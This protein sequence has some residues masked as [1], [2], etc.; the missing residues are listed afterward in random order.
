MRRT[1][2]GQRDGQ[3]TTTPRAS[4]GGEGI[5]RGHR[6]AV[7]VAT[8]RRPVGLRRLLEGLDLQV[9][10]PLLESSSVE[11]IVADNDPETSAQE[12]CGRWSRSSRWPLTYVWEPRRGIAY[13]RNAAVRRATALGA[14]L[15]AFIDDD[16]IPEPFWLEKLLTEM[17][18]SGADVVTGPVVPA[19][20]G[21]PPPWIVSGE[22]FSPQRHESGTRLDRAY[23]N[24]VIVR[25]DV[26]ARVGHL[27]DESTG[28][29]GAEDI[30]FF[31]SATRAGCTIIWAE[32]AWVRESIPDNRTRA[33]WLIR[34]A[35]RDGLRWGQVR[36]ARQKHR[37]QALRG[38]VKGGLLLPWALLQGRAAAVRA[39]RLVAVG[40]GYVAGRA[41]LRPTGY[42]QTDGR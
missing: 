13:A 38:M 27:F 8:H 5:P 33:T 40:V 28:F 12:L 3:G 31:L 35:Y 22:F 25:S 2:G 30:Q 16:E 17:T 42:R 23:T 4:P 11:V 7:C 19:Y 6:I 9:A 39:I 18:R 14:E 41:G 1:G 34:R 29:G 37:R 10:G 36:F 21:P 15:L 24:N 26:F 32:D 20:E